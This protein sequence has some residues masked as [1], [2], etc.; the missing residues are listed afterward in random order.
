MATYG[1]GLTSKQYFLT[2]STVLF[3]PIR[4]QSAMKGLIVFVLGMVFLAL[5]LITTWGYLL[6]YHLLSP[7]GF[8]QKFVIFGIGVYLL[9]GIQIILL[10]LCVALVWV[11]ATKG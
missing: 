8:W 9:G 1:V 10:V 3:K 11:M 4:G 5:A 2:I 7:E 6:V